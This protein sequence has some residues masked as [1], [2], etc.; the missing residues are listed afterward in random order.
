MLGIN[1]RDN[2]SGNQKYKINK[3]NSESSLTETDMVGSDCNTK[4]R[5]MDLKNT[6]PIDPPR[7]TRH[8]NDD[9]LKVAER[10]FIRVVGKRKNWMNM[11]QAYI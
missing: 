2:V 10:N 9:I 8:D 11:E 7:H 3:C 4:H 5:M 6:M 1:L